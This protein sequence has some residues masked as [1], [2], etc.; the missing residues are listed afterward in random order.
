VRGTRTSLVNLDSLRKCY[1][2]LQEKGWQTITESLCQ[3]FSLRVPNEGKQIFD[4]VLSPHEMRLDVV[5]SKGETL[6]AYFS[7]HPSQ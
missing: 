2:L 4:K 5:M 6:P 3:P 1:L 7:S